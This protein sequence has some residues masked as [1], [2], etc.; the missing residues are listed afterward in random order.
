M[1]GQGSIQLA[2]AGYVPYVSSIHRSS[3][4]MQLRDTAQDYPVPEA[5][6]AGQAVVHDRPS[7]DGGD[8]GSAFQLSHASTPCPV[9]TKRPLTPYDLEDSRAAKRPKEKA[10]L[11]QGQKNSSSRDGLERGR[12]I[13]I[14]ALSFQAPPSS[15]D[16]K[17]RTMMY[18]ENHAETNLVRDYGGVPGPEV[19][20]GRTE[21]S[22]LHRRILELENANEESRKLVSDLSSA[23]SQSQFSEEALRAKL[24]TAEGKCRELQQHGEGLQ[25]AL[26]KALQEIEMARS[27]INEVERKLREERTTA[28]VDRR[29]AEEEKFEAV[30]KWK[31]SN[32]ESEKERIRRMAAESVL[33]DVKLLVCTDGV[34]LETS[35]TV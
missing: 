34:A 17:V 30:K 12:T 27:H 33:L 2:T 15:G 10:A 22:E 29:K 9:P 23:L 18:Q 5:A 16:E 13:Q 26:H 28:E 21:A 1:S 32:R 25:S 14:S 6:V 4:E 3:A 8:G 19:G 35:G 20:R 31:E 11:S 24:Q 7:N